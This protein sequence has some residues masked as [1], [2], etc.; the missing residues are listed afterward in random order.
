MSKRPLKSKIRNIVFGILSFI[1]SLSL[2]L[3][4]VCV[5]LEATLF[6]SGFLFDSMNN[7]EYFIDKRDEIA[8]AL[9][10]LTYASN[11]EES[12]F[13]DFLD[14]V[15]IIGDTQEYLDDYYN[16]N[17]NAIIDTTEFTQNLNTALDSYIKEN[18]IQNVDRNSCNYLIKKAADIYSS[19][20]EIPNLSSLALYFSSMRTATA[21]MI[22]V[23]SG[24]AVVV[25]LVLIFCNK[26]KH[27]AAKYICYGVS[28]AFLS[29]LVIP[30]Y[31]FASDKIS[32]I[33][34]SSRALYNMIGQ[35]TGSMCLALLF[36]ALIY[37]VISLGLY[38][39]F[40]YKYH[41]IQGD[42]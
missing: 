21:I 18:N 41:R 32:Y 5:V 14:D 34:L 23:L 12:F 9:T 22:G 2:F 3:L 13:D 19:N 30:C 7:S 1:L 42:D 27:R 36:C 15:M 37:L 25:I 11:L 38:F 16:G 39:Y 10:D 4:S 24:I 28:G 17:T 35:A 8:R 6:N 26:W 40:R 33:D 29:A 31:M 20:L